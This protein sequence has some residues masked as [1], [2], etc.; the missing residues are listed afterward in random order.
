[1]P[2]IETPG[3]RVLGHVQAPS[4]KRTFLVFTKKEMEAVIAKLPEYATSK[5]SRERFPVRARF[6]VAWESSLRPATLAKLGAPENYRVGASALTITDET[7]KSRFGRELPLSVKAREA[8]DVVCPVTGIIFG[9]HDFRTLLR[10][11]ARA[12]GI[13]AY[14]ADRISDY[15][16]R[17]SRLT[18]LG[19][20]T[21]NLSGVMYL[22][23]HKQPATTARYMRP[24]KA[25]AEDVLQAAAAAGQPEFWLHSG[26]GTTAAKRHPAALARKQKPRTSRKDSGF[27]SVRGGGLEPPWLLTASTS[28]L[29][30]AQEAAPTAADAAAQNSHHAKG[31]RHFEQGLAL[32]QDGNYGGALAE[33]KAARELGGGPTV[34]YNMGL[35][36]QALFRY[37]E[38]VDTLQLYLVEAARAGKLDRE[39]KEAVEKVIAELGALI[40][41]LTISVE[42]NGA[43]V[44]IDD[45]PID[46]VVG[47]PVRVVSGTHIVRAT[48]EGYIPAQ[49]EITIAGSRSLDVAFKLKRIAE[50]VVPATPPPTTGRL[51]VSCSEANVS[52]GL[53]NAWRGQAP[54]ETELDPG[55][56]RLALVKWGY[57]PAQSDILITPG[58]TKRVDIV[59]EKTRPENPPPPPRFYQTW[60]FWGAIGAVVTGTTTL[61]I[62][63]Q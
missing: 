51:R 50:P 20:V 25:A 22:A 14:R 29:A 32:Y 39:R 1:M 43:R 58:R 54:L 8:F 9:S 60:W 52:L 4:R 41:T 5:R 61:I 6:R 30:R 44:F 28:I 48:I 31:K 38:A 21:S 17:H 24:Q 10:P 19:Q 55:P 36:Y 45:R 49:Q 3:R 62:S 18:H 23:G 16:F 47:A 35:T 26:C 11:A 42:P 7:D 33:L 63:A 59:C 27:L 34:L 12:A 13:D 40:G 56:H 2:E 57:I 46:L 37:G 15:D 53:D